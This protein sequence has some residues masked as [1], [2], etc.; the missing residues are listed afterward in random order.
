MKK[1]ILFATIATTYIIQM[2]MAANKNGGTN[3]AEKAMCKPN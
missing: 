3:I 2:V 1:S